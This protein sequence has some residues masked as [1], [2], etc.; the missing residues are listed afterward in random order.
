MKKSTDNIKFTKPAL[1]WI[2]GK[3]HILAMP[4]K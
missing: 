1:K 4:A 3:T 2:G